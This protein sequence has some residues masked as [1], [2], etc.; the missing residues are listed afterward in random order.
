MFLEMSPKSHKQFTLSLVLIHRGFDNSNCFPGSYYWS[1]ASAQDSL[2]VFLGSKVLRALFRNLHSL[3]FLP[4]SPLECK[5]QNITFHTRIFCTGVQSWS[6]HFQNVTKKVAKHK[7][8]TIIKILTQTDN[9]QEV[10]KSMKNIKDCN[11]HSQESM[12][13]S[14]E[15]SRTTPPSLQIDSPLER[16]EWGRPPEDNSGARAH[17]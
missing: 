13:Q 10:T 12:I 8:V 15:W 14:G 3:P 11:S 9:T 7:N 16:S 5:F 6:R 17:R 1:T 2:K 4:L